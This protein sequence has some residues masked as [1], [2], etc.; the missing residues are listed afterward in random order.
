MG[1]TDDAVFDSTGVSEAVEDFEETFTE[2][3]LSANASTNTL[4]ASGSH[5]LSSGDA[6]TFILRGAGALPAGLSPVY[7]YYVIATGLTATD[8]RVSTSPG[9]SEVDFT[10]AGIGT[11]FVRGNPS[12]YWILQS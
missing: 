3:L 9:G 10:D 7:T 1:S 6:V 2:L 12:T 8:F 11:F 5:G 4:T